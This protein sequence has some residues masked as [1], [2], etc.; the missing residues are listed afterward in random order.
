MDTRKQEEKFLERELTLSDIEAMDED[1]DDEVSQVEF[2]TFMLVAMQKVDRESK[3]LFHAFYLLLHVF[4]MYHA[5][6]FYLHH[7][8]YQLSIRS[9]MFFTN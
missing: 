8:Y 4:C 3:F 6:M 2:L 7:T 1:N 5:K 9:W